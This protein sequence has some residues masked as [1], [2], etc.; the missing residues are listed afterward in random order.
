VKYLLTISYDGRSYC[1]YQKQKNGVSVQEKLT[2]AAS[3][4]FGEGTKITG[5]SRTDSGV[6]AFRFKAT[7]ESE[8]ARIKSEKLPSAL[9]AHLPADISVRDACEVESGFHPR[10][11]VKEKEYRYIICNA[12]TRD[13]F[14]DG[15]AYFFPKELDEK[16]MNEAAQYLIGKHDFRAFMASGSKIED[17]VREIYSCSVTRDGD[18]VTV[19]VRGNGFLYNMVRIIVGTLISV[20]EGKLSVDDIKTVIESRE[21]KN[22]GPTAPPEG[23]YLYDV[24]Y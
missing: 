18:N 2:D 9:N 17:T 24:T 14:S 22:A 11:S 8:N 6:H 20:S 16:I 15:R 21:R 19:S 7:L 13:P 23:L 12:T 1:G 5:C 3:A 10:Y 4:L